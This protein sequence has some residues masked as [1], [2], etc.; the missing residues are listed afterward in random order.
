MRKVNVLTMLVA[1]MAACLCAE[2]VHA[3]PTTQ[4]SV[5]VVADTPP[6][7]FTATVNYWVYAPN[8]PDNPYDSTV[9][10]TY[11]YTVTNVPATPPAGLYPVPIDGFDVGVANDAG[12]IV[13]SPDD[14]DPATVPPTSFTI[15]PL[16][17]E[18]DFLTNGLG[19]IETGATC[20]QLVIQSPYSPGQVAFNAA[21]AGTSEDDVIIGPVVAPEPY[22]RTIGFWKNRV[23]GKKGLLAFFPDGQLDQIIDEAVA[24][25]TIFATADEL[26]DDLQS[27]GNRPIEV[28]ARQQLAALLLN[29]AAGSLFPAQCDAR[30]FPDN[31]V[32]VDGDGI[33]DMT[34]GDALVQIEA[35]ILSGDP[36]LQLEAKNLADDINNGMGLY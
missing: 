23:A 31:M 27:K 14:Q 30:L 34:V 33:A 22:P 32:D 15:S 8:D 35:Q 5:T 2:F 4:G 12:L 29:L 11:V 7:F 10:Y 1:M 28:R 13:F 9:H 25:S 6:F 19:P 21:F 16:K 20:Q 17:V 24:S 36:T 18:F 26:K 3:A